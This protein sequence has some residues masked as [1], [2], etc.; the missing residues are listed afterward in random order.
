MAL[1]RRSLSFQRILVAVDAEPVA[2]HAADVGRELAHA[3]GATLAFIYVVDPSTVA[4]PDGGIPASELIALAETDGKRVLAG[5]RPVMAGQSIPLEF[6]QVG[7]PASEIVKT[8][9]QWSADLIVIGSHGRGGLSRA[10]LGS[11]AEAVMRHAPCPVLV[12]RA[13]V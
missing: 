5:F 7:T 13:Q 3:L 6:V 9:T 10:L 2:A 12:I 1:Q 11:V 4:A 8:A